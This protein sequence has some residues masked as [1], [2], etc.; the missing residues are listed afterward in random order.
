L[1]ENRKRDE[2]GME[3]VSYEGF[4]VDL[5][6]QIADFVGFDYVIRPVKDGFYGAKEENGTWNG[7]V[8]ELVRHVRHSNS[9]CPSVFISHSQLVYRVLLMLS[10]CQILASNS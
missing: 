2:D 4:C 9:R 5:A 8:G 6:G 7:M 3:V 10:D 1:T